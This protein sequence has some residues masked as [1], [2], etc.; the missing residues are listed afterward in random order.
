M[1]GYNTVCMGC[2]KSEVFGSEGTGSVEC[3]CTCESRRVTCDSCGHDFLQKD[4][5][6][7][8]MFLS[9]CKV[10]NEHNPHLMDNMAVARFDK[11][12]RPAAM[13]CVQPI[14]DKLQLT[15]RVY[16]LGVS[17][18]FPGMT[19]QEIVARW[20]FGWQN[21]FEETPESD[22]VFDTAVLRLLGEYIGRTELISIRR[23]L[24]KHA[25]AT[26]LDDD[27]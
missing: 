18:I 21:S 5:S 22:L 17:I 9:T 25:K 26:A 11:S 2:G 12:D 6:L 4:M 14:G 13:L 1:R 20:I 3:Q 15:M 19:K 16:H 8:N 23:E 24:I 7:N 27:M 10:C